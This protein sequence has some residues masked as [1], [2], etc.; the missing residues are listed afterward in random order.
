ML[1]KLTAGLFVFTAMMSTSSLAEPKKF[2][3]PEEMADFMQ[4]FTV[5]E[6]TFKVISRDP[7]HIELKV[8]AETEQKYA[9]Q[10]M[11]RAFLWGVYRTFLH[12]DASDVRVTVVSP[13]AVDGNKNFTE[14][15]TRAHAQRVARQMLGVSDMSDLITDD[16]FWSDKMKR[17]YYSNLGPP[18]LRE[19]ALAVAGYK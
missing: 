2:E 8:S 4:D 16:Q 19:C 14:S 12:T 10:A 3:T 1:R 17:C 11:F 7:L 6:G 5:E 18:G 9:A 15:A 13:V